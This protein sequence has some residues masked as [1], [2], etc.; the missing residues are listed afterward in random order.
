MSLNKDVKRT[1]ED[2]LDSGGYACQ[3]KIDTFDGK[4][5]FEACTN[6][7]KGDIIFKYNPEYEKK[8]PG[9]TV[10]AARDIARH[11]INHHAYKGFKGCPRTL[12]QHVELIFEP[13]LEVLSAK[14]FG[15]TDAHYIANAFEDTILHADL[16]KEFVLD[17]M[18]D[19]FEDVGETPE[20]KKDI[21]GNTISEKKFT[22]YYEAHAKLNMYLWGNR[23]HKKQL[24]KY[25][26]HTQEI[27]DVL[28][29]F[30]KRTKLSQIG[31]DEHGKNKLALREHLNNEKNWPQLA[32]IY[33]E[34]FSKLMK[35]GYAMQLPN[36]SG[37]GTKGAEKPS[38]GEGEE[39]QKSEGKGES[40]P[41]PED[42]K[43]GNEFDKQ[44]E[45]KEFKMGRVR[46]AHE[47]GEDAPPWIKTYEA[48]DLLYESLAKSLDIVAKSS[49]EASSMPI[50]RIL[51]RQFN[52][53]RDNF[54]DTGY[55]LNDSGEEELYKK[56]QTIDIPIQLKY[57]D[58]GF[59]E[60][61]WGILD[62]SGS[63]EKDPDNGENT[64][65]TN[66]I[67][68]GDNC[69]Y[70]YALL[71]FYGFIEFLKQ[72]MLLSQT[73]IGVV[74]LSSENIVGNGLTEAKK[75]ALTPQFGK[76]IMDMSVIKPLFEG[77]DKLVFTISD[78]EYENWDS[79]K[80]DFMNGAQNHLYFHLQIGDKNQTCYDLE[81]KGLK[82][83]CVKSAED[84]VKK[85]IDLTKQA[86]VIKRAENKN[87]MRLMLEKNPD[88]L[89][90]IFRQIYT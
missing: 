14:G 12:E 58:E 46:K 83:E 61:R 33:A 52:W 26:K 44:M 72:K 5:H 39:K 49:T 28:K 13:M 15:S 43:E 9:K 88:Y 27:T 73:N 16:G 60:A 4:P 57:H 80:N 3:I 67:P 40:R 2:E 8:K 23:Q 37:K 42:Q 75:V 32:S 62:T 34:E 78:G 77:R 66:I 45:T 56:K 22:E 71:S 76:T 84:L 64:G 47:T 11:E 35:P 36:H 65:K 1:I 10:I 24:S 74:N 63:M 21:K 90:Q 85:T 7:Q 29:S 31:K 6:M 41:Q 59:P 69:K 25:Y 18:A 50:D 89:E 68:W 86:L 82:V 51:K 53:E 17:G 87:E 54:R 79:V 70:H 81:A 55:K 48:M 30:L 19:F 38:E 20:L